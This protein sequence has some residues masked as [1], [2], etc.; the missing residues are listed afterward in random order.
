MGS[1][2]G[3]WRSDIVHAILVGM[4]RAGLLAVALAAVY[5]LLAL[6]AY[7]CLLPLNGA[8]EVAKAS[9]CTMPKEQPVRDACDAFKTI[10]VQTLSS[11]QPLPA[12]IA[13]VAAGCLVSAPILVSLPSCQ[14][15]HSGSPP[16]SDRDPLSL[17][18]ILRI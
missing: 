12:F 3:C 2:K 6:N 13:H 5:F 9:D 11:V 4:K 14:Y 7:A 8:A 15:D 1:G 18:S 10:S 16:F 17:I